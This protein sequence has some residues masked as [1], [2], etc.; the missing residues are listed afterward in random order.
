M[1]FRSL[2]RRPDALIGAICLGFILIMA[3]AGSLHTPYDPDAM[4][5]LARLASPG[6]EHW[7]GTDQY[8]RDL[9]SRL[10]RASTT[11]VLISS[12]A[13]LGTLTLGTLL[14]AVAGYWGGWIERALLL[15][16][17]ASLAFPALL[18]VLTLMAVL[19][20]SKYGVVLGL[21]LALA[22]S[23]ARVVRTTVQSLRERDFV[24]AGRLA[25]YSEISVLVRHVLPNC[26]APLTVLGSATFGIALLTESALSFLGLGVPP[27]D[28][29]W[30]GLLA[31]SRQYLGF[32]SWLALYPGIALSIALLGGNLMGDVLRDGLDSRL[33]DP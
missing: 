31:D 4:D 23:V 11:S 27:P 10:L 2:W 5:L 1:T 14:G 25:G 13:V 21:S 26:I 29:T 7:L 18:L 20:P 8:G 28:A 19:G 17:E 12:L 33:R 6:A 9:L 30:G 24:M 3:I 22:P 15:L 32:A 16:V